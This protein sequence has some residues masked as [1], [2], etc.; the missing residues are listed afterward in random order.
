MGER[1][2][3]NVSGGLWMLLSGGRDVD[4]VHVH[5]ALR[6][7]GHFQLSLLYS[8]L[9]FSS[10]TRVHLESRSGVCSLCLCIW[11]DVGAACASCHTASV[12]VCAKP[13]YAFS[14]HHQYC[15]SCVKRRPWPSTHVSMLVVV[16]LVSCSATMVADASAAWPWFVLR[17]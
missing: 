8:G 10:F 13:W 12:L 3:I 11:F 6:S 15:L 7:A 9:A 16:A 1:G 17:C 14:P 4:G 2:F 5:H